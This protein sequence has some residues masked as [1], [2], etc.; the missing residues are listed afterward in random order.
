MAYQAANAYEDYDSYI[1]E[2]AVQPDRLLLKPGVYPYTVTGFVR[3]NY[4]G[5]D[6]M[7]ACKMVRIMLDVD[8]GEAGVAHETDRIYLLKDKS[9]KIRQLFVSAG[10]VDPDA[11][12]F[13]PNWPELVGRSSILKLDNRMYKG[14]KYNDIKRYLDPAEAAEA[15]A[16]SVA[17]AAPAAPW[18]R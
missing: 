7:P 15:A 12:G 14:E 8:G 13:S 11:K 6:N 4:D 2:E 18:E 17:Q 5:G 10:L 1:G 3:D 9:W 16:K